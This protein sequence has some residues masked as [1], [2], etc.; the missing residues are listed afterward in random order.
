V[1]S[2]SD[3]LV[4]EGARAGTGGEVFSA[5]D[6]AADAQPDRNFLLRVA[7]SSNHCEELERRMQATG[8][9]SQVVLPNKH[10]LSRTSAKLGLGRQYFYL[11]CFSEM[12]MG[13][14]TR[15]H[16]FCDSGHWGSIE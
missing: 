2:S 13:F 9:L 10:F 6:I 1:V 16:A 4:G 8:S 3:A 11:V 15:E 7:A 14:L 12:G 5:P